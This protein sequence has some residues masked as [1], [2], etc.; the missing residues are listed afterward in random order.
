MQWPVC[1]NRWK[2]HFKGTASD[3]TQLQSAIREDTISAWKDHSTVGHTLLKR[4]LRNLY[5][6]GSEN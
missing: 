3:I 1:I 4:V 2:P 6:L 5:M